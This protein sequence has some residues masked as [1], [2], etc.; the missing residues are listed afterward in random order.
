MDGL[1][2]KALLNRRE[3]VW[4][5]T[6]GYLLDLWECHKQFNEMAKPMREVSIDDVIRRDIK[7]KNFFTKQTKLRYYS[8]NIKL[9]I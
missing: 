3:E 9:K 7:L 6:L 5:V 1:Y 4:L 2:G 8:W